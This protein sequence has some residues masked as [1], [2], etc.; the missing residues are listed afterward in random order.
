MFYEKY[1][2]KSI[3]YLGKVFES[4]VIELSKLSF[5]GS[6][7]FECI[8]DNG[9]GSAIRKSVNIVFSGKR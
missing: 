5:R 8:A 2:Y 7:S 6:D 4:E 3:E 1:F 9:I